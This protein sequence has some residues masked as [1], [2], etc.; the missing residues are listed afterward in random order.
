MF[1]LAEGVI[2][3]VLGRVDVVCPGFVADCLETLEEIGITARQA[4]LDAGGKEFYAV[5][6]LNTSPEWMATLATICR[7][8]A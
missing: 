7:G 6:C 3:P 4:F 1:V 8:M 5:P 2:S